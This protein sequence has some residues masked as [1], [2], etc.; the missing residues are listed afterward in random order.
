M[1]PVRRNLLIVLLVFWLLIAWLIVSLRLETGWQDMLRQMLPIFVSGGLLI[2]LGTSIEFM[3]AER[4]ITVIRSD[5]FGTLDVFENKKYFMF[6]MLFKIVAKMPA[7]ALTSEAL[8]EMI[9]TQ[10]AKLLRIDYARVRCHYRVD[11]YSTCAKRVFDMTERLPGQPAR[12]PSR[13]TLPS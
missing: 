11:S 8:V 1:S 7:Y 13:S 6:P 4:N 10:T 9:D 12:T 5:I 3:P 2:A